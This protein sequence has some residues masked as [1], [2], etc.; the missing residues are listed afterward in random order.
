[1]YR[2]TALLL[3]VATA[4]CLG[5]A[6]P[7]TPDAGPAATPTDT[8]TDGTPTDTPTDGTPTPTPSP[9]PG[10]TTDPAPSDANTV[11]YADLSPAA[12]A[13]FDAARDGEARFLPD[14]EY[15]DGEFHDPD[16]LGPFRQHEYVSKNGTTYALSVHQG[17]LYASYGIDA[18]PAS[19]G[20]DASVVAYENLSANVSTEVR[21]A[22]EN[23]SHHVPL[24]KWDSY[25]EELGNVDYV[26]YEDETYRLS[27]VVGDYWVQVLTAEPV[28]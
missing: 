9:P 8:Q 13:A 21:R 17:T 18:A 1:M 26:S 5:P 16:A 12:Q 3:I 23:G 28:R 7:A 10:T 11:A 2:L 22:I 20:D 6:G 27:R 25:P 4:G 15:V 14:S 24:G 19:P